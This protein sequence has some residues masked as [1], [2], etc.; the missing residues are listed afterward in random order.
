MY[1]PIVLALCIAAPGIGC[2]SDLVSDF[3]MALSRWK[4]AAIENYTFTYEDNGGGLITPKCGDAQF[5]LKVRKGVGGIPVVARGGRR[6]PVGTRVRA[7][8]LDIPVTIDEAF[9]AIRRYIKDPPTPVQV[10]VTYD[11][12]YGY[13]LTYSAVK[14]EISDS[15]EGFLVANFSAQR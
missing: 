9:N 2:A 8:D 11:S 1:R 5:K 4:S 10:T 3:D 6:C 12:K 15:D 14:L 13:P 7:A